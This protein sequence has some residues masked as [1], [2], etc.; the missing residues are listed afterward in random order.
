M[1]LVKIVQSFVRPAFPSA[2]RNDSWTAP[3]FCEE[4][5]TLVHRK[6]SSVKYEE[7]AEGESAI[8]EIR[9]RKNLPPPSS[10]RN[11]FDLKVGGPSGHIDGHFIA[12][13]LGEQALTDGA[14]HRDLVL[15][16]IGLLF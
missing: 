1:G 3:S 13:L 12:F 2:L 9:W 11:V 7:R 16:D 10:P 5:R 15:G 14:V 6:V 8:E 4:Q